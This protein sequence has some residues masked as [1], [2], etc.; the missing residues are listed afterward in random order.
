MKLVIAEKPSVANTIA[1]VL[2]VTTQSDGYI[3]CGSYLVSWCVGH[4][5]G[6]AMPEAYGSKYAE[7]PWTFNNLP[8]IPDDWKLV[9][10][11]STKAQFIKLK[12]LMNRADVT[13]IICATDAGREGECIFRYVYN[14]IGCSKPVKR[15]WTS[16]LEESA[17]RRGFEELKSDSEY[18]NLFAAG[19][20]RAKADWLVG[21]N[22]TRLFSVRYSTPLSIG[23]VQTPTLAMIVERNHKVTNFIKEKYYTVDLDCG[24]G[25]IACSERIDDCTLAE[26]LKE[27]VNG[28]PA[29]VTLAE[30][31]TKTVNPPKLYDLTSLQRDANRLYGFTAQQ[32][33]DCTQALYEKKLCSYPR[34][35]SQYITEDMYDTAENMIDIVYKIY[36]DYGVVLNFTPNIK[37][38]INNAKVSDHHALM[39]TSEIEHYDLLSLPDAESKILGLI[40]LRLICA[41]APAHKYEATALELRSTAA[42][43]QSYAFRATGKRITD[44]GWKAI[45]MS[46]NKSDKIDESKDKEL[47]PVVE[48]QIIDSVASGISEHYTSPPKQYTDDTLLS[49]METAGNTDYDES[50]D[51]EKKGLGTP[52][53]RA[54]ILENLVT[55]GYVIRDGKKLIPTDKGVKL[56]NC[57]P[58][59]VKSPK[60]TADWEMKLQNIEKGICYDFEFINDIVAFIGEL[61]RKYAAK[62]EGKTFVKEWNVIGRCPKCGKRVFDYP[63]SYACESGKDGCGFVIWKNISGKSISVAQAK[64][65]LEN[66]RTDIIKGFKSKNGKSFDAVLK[67]NSSHSIEFV[68]PKR[69]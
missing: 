32:T 14:L 37:R 4:L 40:A 19:F 61:M 51:V 66:G 42:N 45:E 28:Q 67:L 2:G 69:R 26:R 3:E 44:I 55:R 1:D 38:C 35:D 62:D 64:K 68:F 20:A 7:K 25:L 16:S 52:A 18:D 24:D 15:L 12:E 5:V 58:D 6:L 50:I 65:L 53:T 41:V 13:E 63:K 21:F 29:K 17:I 36:P 60:M 30:R 59:E 39:P 8:I 43:A 47:P 49:A 57:V 56:I 9:A 33:L 48:G 11:S 22:A 54:A 31:K 23:R 46:R 10:N 34:T 27:L